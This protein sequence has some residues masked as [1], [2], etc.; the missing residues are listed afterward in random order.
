MEGKPSAYNADDPPTT[1][2]HI[3]INNTPKAQMK[4]KNFMRTEE[5]VSTVFV[6]KG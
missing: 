1:I 5:Y 4:R 6:R 2:G 3:V